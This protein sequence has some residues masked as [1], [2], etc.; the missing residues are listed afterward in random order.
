MSDVERADTPARSTPTVD[1]TEGRKL[2]AAYRS[3]DSVSPAYSDLHRWLFDNAPALLDAAEEADRLRA[4]W[5]A[6][7][8]NV[9]GVARAQR[10]DAEAYRVERD[11]ARAELTA[12]KEGIKALAYAEPLI[13]HG[14]RRDIERTPSGRGGELRHTPA[15]PGRGFSG[16]P[17]DALVTWSDRLRAL[18]NEGI[19]SSDALSDERASRSSD[20]ADDTAQTTTTEGDE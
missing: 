20:G 12:L 10:A 15:T 19:S 2:L 1:V 9:Q 5:A 3:L 13:V 16:C 6:D 4:E 18:L 11:A 8:Q 7:I 17:G 14:I